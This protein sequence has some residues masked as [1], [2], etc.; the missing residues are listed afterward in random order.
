MQERDSR[1]CDVPTAVD[2]LRNGR[3]LMLVDHESQDPAWHLAVAADRVVLNTVNSIVSLSVGLPCI[4][5]AQSHLNRIQLPLF[6]QRDFVLGAAFNGD[7]DMRRPIIPVAA[8]K[9][10]VLTRPGAAECVTD[11]ARLAGL[12]PAGVLCTVSRTERPKTSPLVDFA[13]RHSLKVFNIA[14]LI[15]HRLAN[16]THIRARDV[17]PLQTRFGSFQF[18]SFDSDVFES[19]TALTKGD[20]RE[21]RLRPPLV[22]I[23]A[24][25]SSESTCTALLTH[26][27]H[28]IEETLGLIHHEG[29]GI[30]IGIPC[31][32][33]LSTEELVRATVI[34]FFQ[35][36]PFSTL[37][38]SSSQQLMAV[39]ICSQILHHFNADHIRVVS[40]KPRRLSSLGDF[41]I[42]IVTDISPTRES[43]EFPR[44]HN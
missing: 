6:L 40:N 36:D 28:E 44:H 11:L 1:F 29:A 15:K 23:E 34:P 17:F 4:A 3:M 2:E 41:G 13:E 22:R 14:E 42:D 32:R 26:L 27:N 16:E 18:S 25:H 20:P 9:Q 5:V 39:G 19:C 21:F 24:V 8:S 10:G 7:N 38:G 33:Q 43:N 37:E 12:S 35:D 31:Q 30:I